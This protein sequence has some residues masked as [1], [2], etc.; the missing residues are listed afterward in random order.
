M[1]LSDLPVVDVV[2][3]LGVVR[4]P[5]P[6]RHLGLPYYPRLGLAVDSA[7]GESLAVQIGEAGNGAQLIGRN[8]LRVALQ[9]LQARPRLI[10]VRDVMLAADLRS[11]VG[12][13]I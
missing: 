9:N 1:N 10:A 8:T 11:V 6:V 12:Q 7:S 4:M 5:T 3:E 2:V 13:H